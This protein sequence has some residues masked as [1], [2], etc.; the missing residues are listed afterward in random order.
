MKTFT[1]GGVHPFDSKLTA[2]EQIQTANLPQTAIFL[3]NQHIGAP[4][5]PVVKKGDEVKVGSLIAEASGF[6]SVPIHSSVSGTVSKIDFAI[7]ATG[8]RVQAIYIKVEGD[9]W[10]DFID[11]SPQLHSSTHLQGKE[12]TDRILKSGIVGLGGACF[13]THVKLTVP[14][15]YKADVLV[16]NGVECEPYLTADHRLMVER[17]AEVMEGIHLLMRSV[18]VEHAIVGIER[19]KPDAIKMMQAEAAKF[20]GIKVVPLKMKYPQGGEKQLIEALTGRKVPA[21]P[22]IPIHVGVIVQNVGT[23][24]AVYEAVMKHKP[25]IERVVTITGK[26]LASPK[27]LFVRLGTPLGD[28]IKE[29]GDLP[30]DAS[31]IISGGPMMGRALASVDTPVCKGTSG[32]VIMS[33]SDANRTM[34]RT[35]IRCGKC[36][37]VCPMGLEPYLL[38][39]SSNLQEWDVLEKNGISSCLECGCCQFTCPSFRPLLDLVRVG[40]NKVAMIIRERKKQ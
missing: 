33:G 28:V 19:N 4:A 20:T 31:K 30:D 14:K 9:E 10:L 35:C 18:S 27:N 34:A 40:K 3:M 12:I 21:P 22:A 6:V 38:A 32:V 37:D 36:V 24:F 23:A 7:D 11:R 39:T 1:L 17:T 13:P 15:G 5:T 26:S 16:I 2:K 25:L 29:C 8:K